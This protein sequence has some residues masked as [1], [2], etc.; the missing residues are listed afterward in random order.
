VPEVGPDVKATRLPTVIHSGIYLLF[1]K[2]DKYVTWT[3]T[4][5]PSIPGTQGAFFPAG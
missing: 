4:P 2:I 5:A 3:T 1:Y